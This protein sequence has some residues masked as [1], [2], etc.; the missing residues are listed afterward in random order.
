M[1]Q[2]SRKARMSK[3]QKD[4]LY[5][6]I[7]K[8]GRDTLDTGITPKVLAERL[9]KDGYNLNPDRNFYTR[10]FRD[11]FEFD[12]DIRYDPDRLGRLKM[13]SYFRL[14]EH[15]ELNEARQS[16]R[17]AQKK[18]VIAIWISILAMVITIIFSILQFF[19]ST[20]ID[21]TQFEKLISPVSEPFL[22]EAG[23]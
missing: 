16:S 10:L 11:A 8:H 5:I 13:E 21:E 17:D 18:A 22:I 2:R 9:E 19:S 15:E 7:L 4:D 12:E 23:R 20:T 3:K 14:L 6:A 1:P